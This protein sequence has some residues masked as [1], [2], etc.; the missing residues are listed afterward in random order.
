LATTTDLR[1]ISMPLLPRKCWN[2]R[3]FCNLS[4]PNPTTKIYRVSRTNSKIP[5]QEHRP[6]RPTGTHHGRTL[7]KPPQWCSNT[8][9]SPSEPNLAPI[10]VQQTA[11][12]WRQLLHGRTALAWHQYIQCHDPTINSYNFFAKIIQTCWQTILKLWTTRNGHLHPP[13]I[14]QTDRSQLRTTV[15]RIFHEATL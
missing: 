11:I 5:H 12:G 6:T 10:I 4:P 7:Q 15:E 2:R 13:I 14:T 9:P 8:S 3:T 1:T